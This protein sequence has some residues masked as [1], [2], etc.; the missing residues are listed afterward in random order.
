M[1]VNWQLFSGLAI[2]YV[3]VTIIYWQ[4]GAALLVLARWLP[5]VR[6]QPRGMRFDWAGCGWRL[7]FFCAPAWPRAP[8]TCGN[9]G[10]YAGRRA[11]EFLNDALVPRL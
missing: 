8:A 6:P 10:G 4:I 2:F 3:I 7:L 9:A 1:K 11:R 5:A